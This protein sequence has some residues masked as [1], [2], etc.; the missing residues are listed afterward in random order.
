[1]NALIESASSE[2]PW[3]MPIERIDVAD[4]RLYYDDVWEPYFARLRRDD[5]VDFVSDRC[6]ARSGQ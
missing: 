1:M 3:T 5:P 6:M 4:P 2:D